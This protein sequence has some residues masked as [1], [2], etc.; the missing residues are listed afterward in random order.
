MPEPT[1]FVQT[2]GRVFIP[3]DILATWYPWKHYLGQL[4]PHN[5]LLSDV[6][7]TF[8]PQDAFIVSQLRQGV[9]PL[10]DPTILGGHPSLAN[11]LSAQLYPPRLLLLL[12]FPPELAHDL[13]L[14]LHTFLAGLFSL[15]LLRQLGVGRFGATVGSVAWMFNG[16]VMVWLEYGHTIAIAALLPL[17]LLL[18]D[19]A[20]SKRSPPLALGAGVVVALALLSGNLQR[21]LYL[22]LILSCYVVYRAIREALARRDLRSLAWPV[23][24]FVLATGVGFALSAAALLP[25]FELIGLSQRHP[26]SL[27]DLFPQRWLRLG[28]LATFVAPEIAGGPTHA[29]DL[30]RLALTNANEFQGYAGLLPLLLAA[31]GLLAR[32]GP[33]LFLGALALFA[34]LM[35]LGT[36]LYGLFYYL[37]PGFDKLG[38][39][40]ILIAYAFGI[41]ML[42]GFGADYLY[43]AAGRGLAARLERA[44]LIGLSLAAVAVLA[45]NVVVRL[46]RE[47][48]LAYGKEYVR[49]HVYG[50]PLNPR[51]LEAYYQEIEALYGQLLAHYGLGSRAVLLPFLLAGG[52]VGVLFLRRHRPRLF[53]AA[54]LALVAVDLL[55]FGW[56]Y[57]PTVDRGLIY[58]KTPAIDFLLDDRTLSRVALDTAEG[59]LFPDTLQPFGIHEVGGYESLY[60]DRYAKLLASAEEGSPDAPGFGNHVLLTRFE[61]PLLDL[62]N[63]KYVLRPP[64]SPPPGERFLKVYDEDVAIFENR[65]VLPRA[66]VASECRLVA[67]GPA[68][69]AA[70][71]DP[72]FAPRKTVVVEESDLATPC[73]SVAGGGEAEIL[74]Y[75]PHEVRI[76][77]NA[78]AGGWLVLADTYYPGW[79]ATVDG[80][81]TTVLQ[82]DY[83][84]RGVS[85]PPGRH[86]VA[87]V[88]APA[89]FGVG[90]AI[91]LAAAGL[92]LSY[93]GWLATRARRGPSLVDGPS[94]TS[95]ARSAG[96]ET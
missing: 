72:A 40:R 88:Y 4:A 2:L 80:A 31:A 6:I 94:P 95:V 48:I 67:G 3:A 13:G 51:S 87:F 32:R 55:Y 16:F 63:V 83:A 93:W 61:S 50:T 90:A 21:S 22:L 46:G 5:R 39:Q 60:P 26:V 19:R 71:H 47:A 54:C 76:A 62:L 11:G 86:E 74:S 79:T 34:L 41:A 68:A 24:C 33:A 20:V 15:L 30:Y 70:L 14:V 91:S 59:T 58:P 43:S 53:P 45:L 25:T 35:A 37:V 7:N 42:A 28:L 8:Y 96:D 44:L 75:G 89:T 78:P 65:S 9:F 36:P 23:G 52:C 66:F 84:L 77:T 57:N 69:L 85:L 27:A 73:Q 81:L 17:T 56:N 1:L 18:Y 38:P 64:G 29:V 49:T 10:W 12:L 92:L 82:V